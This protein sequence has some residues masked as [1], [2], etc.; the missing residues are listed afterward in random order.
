MLAFLRGL[1]QLTYL[2]VAEDSQSSR[3]SSLVKFEEQ[4][5]GLTTPKN[6]LCRQNTLSSFVSFEQKSQIQLDSNVFLTLLDHR[7]TICMSLL[8]RTKELEKFLTRH[9]EFWITYLLK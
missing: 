1:G 3:H 8:A 2:L 6:S 4:K 5:I 9:H 7:L